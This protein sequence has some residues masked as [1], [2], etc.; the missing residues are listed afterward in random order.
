MA[1]ARIPAI[2]H[3]RTNSAAHVGADKDSDR[4]QREAIATFVKH[5]GFTVIEEFYD[6][7]VS[8]ADPV[9]IRPGF[10]ALLERIVG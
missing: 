1:K 8:G 9:D 4:R 5:A 10:R 3:L 7:A 6:A 2:A